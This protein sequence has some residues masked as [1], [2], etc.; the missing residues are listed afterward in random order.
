MAAFIAVGML[1]VPRLGIEADEA[2]VGNGI[3]EY[4]APFYSW[5]WGAS[6]LPVMLLSYLGALKTW[7]YNLLFLATP[8]RP[9]SLRLPMLLI[10]AATLG[11]FF[12]LLDRTVSRRTA[13]IGTVLLAS[14]SSY[15][16]M[17]AADYGPVTLQFFLKL[18]AIL[19]ILRFHRAGSR[20]ALAGGFFLVGLA[21][22]DKA[23]FLWILFGLAAATLAVFPREVR[24]LLTGRNIGVAGAAVLVGA[25]PLVIFNIAHPLETLRT[26]A[27]L[28]TA[29]VQAKTG[30]LLRT[31]DGQLL[32]GFMT[33]DTPGP[34]PGQP[35]HWFQSLSLR[36]AGW[37]GHP[38]RNAA[39]A[40]LLLALAALPFLWRTDARAPIL[41]GLIT[42]AAT[43]LPMA[44]TA[45][46]GWAAQH[47]IL[48]WP[49]HFLAIAAALARAPLKLAAAGCAVLCISN[50]AVTNQYYADL[51]RNGPA[52]RWTDAI[53]PL[54][55]YLADSKPGMVFG[56]DW[57]FV[58]TLNLIDEGRLPVASVDLPGPAIT[59]RMLAN[60]HAVFVSH[61]PP[62]TYHPEIRAAVEDAARQEGYAEERLATI[63][64]RNGRPTFD[65]LRFRK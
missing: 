56:A 25:L 32:F 4:G 42:C 35:Q 63:A 53:D 45:N 21:L 7:L 22:W 26:N 12:T 39:L 47:T 28:D 11:L 33:A 36:A 44:L 64:D 6:E 1:F 24:R 8:P 3:Y 20:W 48:L 50:A 52:I 23:V 16:L 60:P 65:V 17:N 43:W 46:A 61:T 2:L 10:A 51:I 57:G 29:F 27:N 31:I 38:R 19:L 59:R 15:L 55:R 41:F 34:Q 58:E 37:T 18:S 62:F 5:K 40:A 30:L 14:D 13:W 49:F 54:N 9:I